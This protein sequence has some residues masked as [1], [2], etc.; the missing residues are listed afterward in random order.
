MSNSWSWFVIILVVAN[1]LAMVWLLMASSNA[2]QPNHDDEAPHEWDGI[3]ELNNPLPRWW[4]GLFMITIVYSLGY[5]YFYPGLGNYAGSLGWTQMSQFESNQQANR[6]KQDQFFANYADLT[7]P[8]LA[9]NATAMQ[10]GQ[11][12]YLNNCATCHGSAGQGAK[13]FPR[14]T[15]DDWLIDG[16]PETIYAAIANGR[17][18]MMPSLGISRANV[19]V[20]AQ[21][22][23]SFSGVEV[24]DFVKEKGPSL[25][26]VCTACHGADG[27]GNPALAA[28]N[29]TDDIWMHGSRTEDIEHVIANGVQANMPSFSQ[30]LSENEMRLLA[31]Y[32]LSIQETSTE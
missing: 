29:L 9:Q 2:D 18:G 17:Q 11:R 30:L 28:P 16:K 1:I 13:G 26:Q 6:A 14:L 5:L 22:I 8:E 12:L 31:A 7:I 15:D 27:K 10:S 3:Q 25:F 19:V 21:Y 20:L 4:Y 32:V 24:T 23:Q